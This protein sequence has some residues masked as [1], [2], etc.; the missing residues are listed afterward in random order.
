MSKKK[1][2]IIDNS[3]YPTGALRSI[4]NV[5]ALLGTEYSFCFAIST[6]SKVGPMLEELGYPV[7]RIPFLEISKS[8]KSLALYLPKLMV[9]TRRLLRIVRKEQIAIVH[10]NDLFN[11]A[12]SMLKLFSP[13]VPVIYHVRLLASSYIGQLYGL[14]ARLIRRFAD[15]IICVSG[16]VLQDIGSSARASIIYDGMKAEEALPSWNGLNSPAHAHILYLGNIVRG[17][18][19]QWGLLAFAEAAKTYPEITLEYSG[20]VNSEADEAFQQELKAIARESGIANRV[21]FT[22]PTREVE[23]KMKG[24]DIVLNM[25]E[26]E[27]FSMV[28]LEAMIYGVPLVASDCGGPRD[29]TDNGRMAALVANKS[30][31]EAARAILNIL[32]EPEAAKQ[33]AIAAKS[34]AAQKYSLTQSAARLKELY[35]SLHAN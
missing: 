19:Q 1:I 10:V 11:Q 31:E 4:L 34:Y 24:A 15:R 9:N 27:S 23:Q 8:P 25:S 3:L 35:H 20:G 2:L 26:S 7:Y 33:K 17:K 6:E 13:K 18:G 29:I 21:T 14:F 32:A 12:G 16:A 28:C 5:I 22:G 30:A